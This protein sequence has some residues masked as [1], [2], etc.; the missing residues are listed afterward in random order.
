[1]LLFLWAIF[2]IGFIL[3]KNSI[4]FKDLKV[5]P[6]L[7][8]LAV[9]F[10]YA[11]L[12][13]LWSADKPAALV[14][15]IFLFMAFSLIFLSVYFLSDLG[16]VQGFFFIWLLMFGVLVLVGLWEIKTGQH[17]SISRLA[18]SAHL[19]R[20]FAP[21]AFFRN[22]ND[23]ATVL[24]LGLP[25][26]LVSV[27]YYRNVLIRFVSLS[28][29]SLGF[30]VLIRTYS[31]ANYV[32]VLMGLFFWFLFLLER[33]GKVKAFLVVVLL[34]CLFFAILPGETLNLFKLAGG[35]LSTLASCFLGQTYQRSLNVRLNLFKNALIFLVRS[36]GLGVGAGNSSFYMANY[37]VYDTQGLLPL[38]SW[39]LSIL[40]DYGLLILLGYLFFYI[41]LFRHLFY[42][43]KNLKNLPEKAISEGLLVG[44][45]SFVFAS[46]SSSSI[47]ALKPHWLFFAFALAFLNYCL[48]LG[49]EKAT[50]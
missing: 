34:A 35:Q 16:G 21:S 3:Q 17:F 13:L 36:Y 46:M 27:R 11:T 37:Q 29:L 31:R 6:Y 5:Y 24:T 28:F 8:F 43:W 10:F 20:R 32:A 7:I 49:K 41:M 42:R 47:I 25:F 23:L 30:Y 9:W 18:Q 15:I 12:S 1:L 26:V 45:V 39:F 2:F 19:N 38:H 40:T 4:V 14:D 48:N 22:E 44:L 33:K 50:R